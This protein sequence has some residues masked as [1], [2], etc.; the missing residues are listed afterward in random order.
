MRGQ[1]SSR[2]RYR[3]P[4]DS[5]VHIGGLAP[6]LWS[7][8]YVTGSLK[9]NIEELLVRV[10]CTIAAI[11]GHVETIAGYTTSGFIPTSNFVDKRFKNDGK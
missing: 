11:I 7:Q 5:R 9:E 10:T 4:R 3:C 2:V 8:R 1:A 6:K